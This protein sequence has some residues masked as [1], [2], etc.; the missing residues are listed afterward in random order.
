MK[1]LA[2]FRF[3][4]RWPFR[5]PPFPPPPPAS[6]PAATTTARFNMAAAAVGTGDSPP[7]SHGR[8]WKQCSRNPRHLPQQ[9]EGETLRVLQATLRQATPSCWPGGS[10]KATTPTQ[11]HTGYRDPILGDVTAKQL[12]LHT[13][14]H[15]LPMPP[16]GVSG[17]REEEQTR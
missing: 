5:R 15:F 8:G 4:P 11:H 13:T 2:G 17:S 1:I 6:L 7:L 14:E 3:R 9:T 10:L 16:E 12:E